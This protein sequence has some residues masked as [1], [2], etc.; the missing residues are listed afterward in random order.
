M[1]IENKDCKNELLQ[2]K[3]L[4]PFLVIME[5][6]TRIGIANHENKKLT[7][8]CHI[9]HNDGKYYLAHFKTL[10]GI[11]SKHS[12]FNQTDKIRLNSIAQ[13]LVNWKM[14]DIIDYDKL[15]TEIN[16]NNIFILPHSE[17][18]KW[19]LAAM[20]IIPDN[21]QQISLT[22]I[23]DTHGLHDSVKLEQK[24]DILIHCGDFMN[25]GKN[26]YEIES[27]KKWLDGYRHLYDKVLI[28]AGNHDCMFERGSYSNLLTDNNTNNVFYLE[29]SGFTYKGWKFWG[30]PYT[31]AFCNWA[32]NM[33]RDQLK[34]NWNSIPSD[35]NVLITHGPSLGFLDTISKHNVEN[36][37]CIELNL[38]M[39]TLEHLKLHCFGHIH[40]G[41]GRTSGINDIISINASICTE[42]YQP[43]ND[44]HILTLK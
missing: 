12:S 2:I 35:T 36:L 30:S 8:S 43:I 6:L 21:K 11:Y 29:N 28:I 14:I 25:S 9:W 23:S 20:F 40:G 1:D 39:Y 3:L 15:D 42:Q 33:N 5:T 17:K 19:E 38:K 26:L 37:G 18:H 41:Y 16:I 7:Q 10:F 32:F 4:K 24:T 13:I 44:P 22:I 34:E 31:P 27:F